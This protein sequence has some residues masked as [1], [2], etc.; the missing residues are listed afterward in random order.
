MSAP[1]GTVEMRR[2]T[3]SYEG[4]GIVVDYLVARPPYNRFRAGYLIE[5]VKHQIM[6]GLHVC[7]FRDGRL[8]GYSGWLPI[9]EEL[10]TLWLEG[11]SE[12][13]AVPVE[14]S[15][16]A[17]LTIVCADDTAI[18][19]GLIRATRRYRPGQR[20]FFRRDYAAT[21]RSARLQTVVNVGNANGDRA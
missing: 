18:V 9:T 4:L 5:A 15:N 17:A 6:H 10:G 19:R 16:A 8:I 1:I 20:V 13:I 2:F 3:P 21:A 11:R 12:L 14:R 7:A